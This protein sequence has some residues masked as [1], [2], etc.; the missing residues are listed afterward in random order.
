MSDYYLIV[1]TADAEMKALENTRAE[2]MEKLT[3]VVELTRGRK[4]PSKEKHRR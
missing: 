3:P 1:K 2:V 4:L